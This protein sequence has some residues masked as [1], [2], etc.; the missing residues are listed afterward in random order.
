MVKLIQNIG[1]LILLFHLKKVLIKE[2]LED[3][4]SNVIMTDEW[5]RAC[6]L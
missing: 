4:G 6:G 5:Y 1:L 2:F 3:L